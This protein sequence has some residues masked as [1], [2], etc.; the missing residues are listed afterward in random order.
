[1]PYSSTMRL[2]YAFALLL[3]AP[4][5][6]ADEPRV[7][8]AEAVQKIWDTAP[9]A[10]L[11]KLLPSGDYRISGTVSELEKSYSNPKVLAAVM[12]HAGKKHVRLSLKSEPAKRP[13]P[14][15]S[16]TASCQFHGHSEGGSI[17]FTDCTL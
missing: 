12:L 5:A 17:T 7:L 2:L 10:D 11:P 4:L 3:A 1:M 13:A 8:T 15:A 16:V 6:T 14:G 9:P